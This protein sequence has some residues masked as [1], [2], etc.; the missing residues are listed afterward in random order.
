MRIG[1]GRAICLAR[2]AGFLARA[3]PPPT[4]SLPR[5]GAFALLAVLLTALG[6]LSTDVFRMEG[7][8][9]NGASNMGGA[10]GYSVAHLRQVYAYKPPLAYWLAKLSFAAFGAESGLALR[11]PFALCALALAAMVVVLLSCASSPARSLGRF[12]DSERLPARQQSWAWP[13]LTCPSR[14][15]WASPPRP[16]RS[17]CTSSDPAP[18]SGASRT[19]AWPSRS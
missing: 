7:L 5:P 18:A 9:A 12:R 15:V 13:P 17:T 8:I 1:R 14:R 11:A 6:V 19:P 4:H 16:R 3:C 2:A 10:Q